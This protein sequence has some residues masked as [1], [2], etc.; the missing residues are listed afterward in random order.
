MPFYQRLLIPGR[1][2]RSWA[3]VDGLRSIA[4]KVGATVAQLAIA[5]VLHQVGV[6]AAIAG[7]R[8]GLHVQENARV[9]R[10]SPL[11]G[12]VRRGERPFIPR[13]GVSRTQAQGLSDSLC[14]QS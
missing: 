7:S 4:E 10:A 9:T 5:W 6:D 1:A 13:P 2:E 3:V 8:S 14:K 12:G 11:P